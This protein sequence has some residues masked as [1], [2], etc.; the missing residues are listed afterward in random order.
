LR[1][2][3]NYKCLCALLAISAG[4]YKEMGFSIE[5]TVELL[6]SAGSAFVK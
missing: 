1:G 5:E 2:K 6:K 4:Q 3:D